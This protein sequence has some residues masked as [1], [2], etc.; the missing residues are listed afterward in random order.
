MALNTFILNGVTAME[1]YLNNPT[2]VWKGETFKCVANTINDQER[3]ADAGFSEDADFRMTVRLNQFTPNIYPALNDYIIHQGYQL[4][5]KGIRKPA[6]GLY[7][8]YI[9]E[10]PNIK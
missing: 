1:A 7:W 5:I 3:A 4:L 6:H 2:F 10:L 8:V 9:C